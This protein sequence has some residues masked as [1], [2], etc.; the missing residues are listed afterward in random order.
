MFYFASPEETAAKMHDLISWYR[1]EEKKEDM[2]AVSLA[3]LF[4]YKFVRIHPFDDGNGRTARLLMNFI[5]M[6]AGFPPV[7]I[8]T[9]D[10]EA[11]LTALQM[12]DSG[13]MEPFIE[14]I[15]KELIR[16]LELML[17]AARGENI[18]EP[19]DLDKELALLEQR[20]K[21]VTNPITVTYSIEAVGKIF[22]GSISKVIEAFGHQKNKFERFYDE[23]RGTLSVSGGIIDILN[24]Q[25]TISWNDFKITTLCCLCQ[26]AGTEK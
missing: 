15:A 7:V 8:K 22:D 1:A 4:H 21:S 2:N 3:A 24:G 20:I 25:Q 6:K 11:Y 23:C 16:S 17:A 14:A 9:E 19:D 13:M 26:I 10:K 5:L 18:E 12:A